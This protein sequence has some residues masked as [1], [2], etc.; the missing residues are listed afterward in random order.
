[1]EMC[2]FHRSWVKIISLTIN[3]IFVTC[4]HKKNVLGKTFDSKLKWTEQLSNTT[5]KN[6]NKSLLAIKSISKYF[7]TNEI[8]N[9]LTFNFYSV[10]YYNSEKWH[11][12]KLNTY[13]KNLVISSS[14]RALKFFN[15]SQTQDMWYV[16][17]HELS[18]RVTPEQFCTYKHSLVLHTIYNLETLPNEWLNLNFNQAFNQREKNFIVIDTSIYKVGKNKHNSQQI[19]MFK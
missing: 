17:L 14:A 13:L 9:L 7:T 2:L 19:N 4:I 8:K 5:V 3:I 6:A 10:F 15:P 12:L 1:M 18:N 11:L 16:K